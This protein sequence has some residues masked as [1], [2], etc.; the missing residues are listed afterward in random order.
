[1]AA[2]AWL[3]MKDVIGSQTPPGARGRGQP[4]ERHRELA[5]P[6]QTVVVVFGGY[7]AWCG[8]DAWRWEMVASRRAA[9]A[10]DTPPLFYEARA[11]L[12]Q[13]RDFGA[14]SDEG[15]GPPGRER[16]ADDDA[17]KDRDSLI[18]FR[19]HG[20]ANGQSSGADSTAQSIG[21]EL[22]SVMKPSHP[23]RPSVIFATGSWSRRA[24]S[25]GALS[26]GTKPGPMQASTGSSARSGKP[27]LAGA[28][29]PSIPS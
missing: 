5:G 28:P 6:A 18:A 15:A 8:V 1:M 13:V 29:N 3:P 12:E 7:V 2:S 10:E 11:H 24:C 20:S 4:G 25:F 16:E 26:G 14:F 22:C 9:L 23:S 17:R 19:W 21:F 27:A